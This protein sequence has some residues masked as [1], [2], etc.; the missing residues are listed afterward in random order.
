MLTLL[1]VD[2]RLI[3]GQVVQ[4]WL[5][6]L[7]AERV[8]VA[9]DEAAANPLSCA[10]MSLALAGE[11]DFRCLP[12]SG[13]NFRALA[14]DKVRTLV[15]VRDVASAVAAHAA[16]CT[17]VPVNVGNVHAAAGR[18]QVTPSVFLSTGELSQLKML[19]DAGLTVEVRAVP[20]ERALGMEE[21]S[22]RLA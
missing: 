2:N 11:A 18:T 21:L 10:A 22:R 8:V 16:G 7:K 12:V 6:A 3:H 15:L 19:A 9:D 1:R 14:A 13:V 17:G 20:S 5:P 4:A